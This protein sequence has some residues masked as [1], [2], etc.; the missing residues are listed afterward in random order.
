MWVVPHHWLTPVTLSP[1]N[2]SSE[3]TPPT[4]LKPAGSTSQATLVPVLHNI[5]PMSTQENALKVRK[6]RKYHPNKTSTTPQYTVSYSTYYTLLTHVD[7]NICGQEW[8]ASSPAGTTN[9]FSEYWSWAKGTAIEKVVDFTVEHCGPQELHRARNCLVGANLPTTYPK[10]E[11]CMHLMH[12]A[13]RGG[14]NMLT[15]ALY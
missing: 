1:A 8:S 10:M 9:Q 7:S 5:V 14:Y 11:A 13:D 12:M 15:Y 4:I 6:N 3:T 2:A